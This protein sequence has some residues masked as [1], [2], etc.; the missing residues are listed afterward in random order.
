M[1]LDNDT[2][3]DLDEIIADLATVALEATLTSIKGTGWSSAESLKAI[4]TLIDLLPTGVMRGTDNALLAASYVTERGT[5]SAMLATDGALEATL[6]TIK[7][8]SWSAE[9]LKAIYDLIASI[10][11]TAMRGTDGAA[12]ASAWTPALATALAAYTAARGVYLDE[13][14]AANLPSDVDAIFNIVDA[15]PDLTRVSGT[16]TATGGVDTVYT[17]NAPGANLVVTKLTVDLTNLVAGD[18]VVIRYAERTKTGGNMITSIEETFDGPQTVDLFVVGKDM[19]GENLWGFIATLE[20]TA[21][22]NRDFDWQV[23]YEA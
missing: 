11:T 18:T 17:N 4:K 1:S 14:A 21:G 19:L 13:L 12:L 16:L 6:T 22:V 20:Q 7:G 15:I 23:F 5:D 10:P 9:T 3:T 2:A 8:V